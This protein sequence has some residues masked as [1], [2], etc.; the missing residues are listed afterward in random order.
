MKEELRLKKLS[1]TKEIYNSVIARDSEVVKIVTERY[2]QAR[3][4]L[5]LYDLL[6]LVRSSWRRR[7][8]T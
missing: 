2:R 7:G 6:P 5:F 1:A 4:F 3:I 8:E